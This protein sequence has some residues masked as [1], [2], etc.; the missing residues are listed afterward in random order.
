MNT[1][2]NFPFQFDGRGRTLNPQ[3]NYL[4]QL[5]RTGSLHV[6]RRT[7]QP[8]RLRQ[9]TATASFRTQQP[10][11]G[12]S[13][14]VQRAGR[15]AK[16]AQQLRPRAVRYRRCRRGHTHCHRRLLAAQLGRH[17]D[18]DLRLWGSRNDHLRLLQRKSQSCHTRNPTLNGIDYLE[19]LDQTPS[20]SPAPRQRTLLLHFLNT[21]PNKNAQPN[22][23]LIAA[24]KASLILPSNGRRGH[25]PPPPPLTNAQEAAYFS[26][27]PTPP[28]S[29]WFASTVAGDF[30]PYRVPPRQ[31]RP[32]GRRIPS[33]S[34]SLTGFDPATL[35]K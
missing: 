7:R 32:S 3:E 31:Q 1:N 25:Q 20:R 4:R 9:R 35:C 17:R 27:L 19:V 21:A 30:S 10:G 13:H 11:D 12:G 26:A 24:E 23:V 5:R 34:P 33:K 6:A 29:W 16:V 14:P 18:P 28:K 8:A 15:P 2:V 22:N